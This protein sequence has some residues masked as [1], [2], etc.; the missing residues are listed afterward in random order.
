ML[1]Q[2]GVAGVASYHVESQCLCQD[3]VLEMDK[4]R[5]GWFSEECDMWPGQKFSL[6]VKEVIHHEKTKYQDILIF[7]R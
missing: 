7:Q 5:H 2:V 6:A 4:L 3:Y 1:K